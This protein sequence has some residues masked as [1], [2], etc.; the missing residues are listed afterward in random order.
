MSG[1]IRSYADLARLIGYTALGESTDFIAEELGVSE[2]T[3][4]ATWA[5]IDKGLYGRPTPKPA[6]IPA[7]QPMPKPKYQP[8]KFRS[9]PGLAKMADRGPKDLTASLMGDP[10]AAAVERSF[11]KPAPFKDSSKWD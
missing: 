8:R 7:P 11:C 10:S 1:L 3:V 5:A 2:A 4:N 6:H 9:L